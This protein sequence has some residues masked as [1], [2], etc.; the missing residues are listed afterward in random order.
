MQTQIIIDINNN[1]NN[2][3]DD[4]VISRVFK[5]HYLLKKILTE[6]RDDV[7]FLGAYVPR[8][9]LV[10]VTINDTHRQRTIRMVSNKRYKHLEHDLQ[11]VITNRHFALL[12][13]ILLLRR[14]NHHLL[15]SLAHD[16][17]EISSYCVISSAIIDDPVVFDL[18]VNSYP[19]CFREHLGHGGVGKHL[20]L[21]NYLQSMI[22]E[23]GNI[24]VWSLFHN[25]INNTTLFNKHNNINNNSQDT[26]K[27]KPFRIFENIFGKSPSSS[28]SSSSSSSTSSSSSSLSQQKTI[29]HKIQSMGER[30]TKEIII[31]CI[32]YG[33]KDILFH[34]LD[35]I[36]DWLSDYIKESKDIKVSLDQLGDI[37]DEKTRQDTRDM[38]GELVKRLSTPRLVQLLSGVTNRFIT[39]YIDCLVP[40]Y[41]TDIIH[42]TTIYMKTSNPLV[43]RTKHDIHL[44]FDA[45]NHIINKYQDQFKFSTTNINNIINPIFSG[46]RS[47]TTTTTTTIYQVLWIYQVYYQF[48]LSL[49]LDIHPTK[50]NRTFEKDLINYLNIHNQLEIFNNL[51]L[52]DY[53]LERCGFSYICQY[54]CLE[55]VQQSYKQLLKNPRANNDDDR[56]KMNLKSNDIN[57]LEFI[58]TLINQYDDPFD[59]MLSVTLDGQINLDNLVSQMNWKVIEYLVENNQNQYF[60]FTASSNSLDSIM[61]NG[62]FK[63][64]NSL[65]NLALSHIQS[66][67]NQRNLVNSLEMAHY[68]HHDSIV[69]VLGQDHQQN[70]KLVQYYLLIDD[71]RFL[72]QRS[73]FFNRFR[74]IVD[75]SIASR[76]YEMVLH[77]YQYFKDNQLGR[78]PASSK[79][80]YFHFDLDFM[81]QNL[82]IKMIE[83]AL[84]LEVPL[85]IKSDTTWKIIAKWGTIEWINQFKK[86]IPTNLN[87][88]ELSKGAMLNFNIENRNSIIKY[89]ND[90]IENN[91]IN[92]SNNKKRK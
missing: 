45:L 58:M 69:P 47:N 29:I 78:F 53:L 8:S 66:F 51:N 7:C 24:Q 92:T 73:V 67:T 70:I 23:H 14:R 48:Y 20:T 61:W 28:L 15:K 40:I 65:S 87:Y 59:Q 6:I 91:N 18:L 36:G 49:N 88:F 3:H 64:I 82:D 86:H 17:D 76:D 12:K 11:W 42:F 72:N 81:I 2:N 5:N 1:N 32:Q 38:I 33:R 13:D 41:E 10:I 37:V 19:Q 52:I 56:F 62:K 90:L 79:Q 22:I 55:M 26:T 85:S 77:L 43:N 68:Y 16:D 46:D 35:D 21:F 60:T 39:N 34:I 63:L 50:D 31:T 54:G 80:N 25:L 83:I 9:K 74:N 71:A 84:S 89:C 4:D 27:K 44:Q 57:V 30:F 75:I